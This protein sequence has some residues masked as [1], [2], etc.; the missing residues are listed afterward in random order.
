LTSLLLVP[1][2]R[3]YGIVS[4]LP[5][6]WDLTNPDSAHPGEQDFFEILQKQFAPVQTNGG[7]SGFPTFMD[8]V[9]PQ[10]LSLFPL[11]N[12]TPSSTSEDSSPSP[13]TTHQ[14]APQDGNAED[15]TLKRKASTNK[16][17]S[18]PNNKTQ[19]TGEAYFKAFIAL[20]SYLF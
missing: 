14:E 18:E 19:H 15:P 10:N 13:P 7:I 20:S 2:I 11:S 16:L 8:G 9:N 4:E 6:I 1:I 5:A 3:T 12:L 17:E